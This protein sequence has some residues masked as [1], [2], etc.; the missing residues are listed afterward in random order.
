ML[1]L[2]A[3]LMLPLALLE[4]PA[5]DSTAYLVAAD[6]FLED[7][8]SVY[9]SNV[10]P[11]S[12]SDRSNPFTRTFCDRTSDA[13]CAKGV[14]GFFSAPS[15]LPAIA[16][17]APLPSTIGTAL[18]RLLGSA[19]VVASILVIRQRNQHL[20][21][22]FLLAVS[23]ALTPVVVHTVALGQ[24]TPWVM[25]LA[26]VGVVPGGVLASSGRGV[27]LAASASA[28][29][30]PALLVLLLLRH[31]RFATIA[32][33]AAFVLLAS[34][35]VT[36]HHPGIWADALDALSRVDHTK[37]RSRYQVSMS[38]TIPRLVPALADQTAAIVAATAVA[39]L[40]SWVRWVRHLSPN[41][42]WA[43]LTAAAALLSTNAWPHYTL[44]AVPYLLLLSSARWPVAAWITGAYCAT[45]AIVVS[46]WGTTSAAVALYPLGLLTVL[47]LTPALI[48][49]SAE[50]SA[51]DPDE[52]PVA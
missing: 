37:G 26:A 20:S 5:Q 34:A 14:A 2:G 32:A 28:K 1:L 49:P 27:L 6:L 46:T 35:L 11:D 8:E 45:A 52:R 50:F 12:D 22:V 3:W 43:W 41:L 33:A 15:L 21:D 39:L 16:P 7:P 51:S 47:A 31:R 17:L 13:F 18:Q 4:Q 42:E 40:A 23:I 30:F 48:G 9:L 38:I 25:L 24:S 44:I 29:L 10:E 19:A 36:L